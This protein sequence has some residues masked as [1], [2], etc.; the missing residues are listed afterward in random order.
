MIG[1]M[2]V[3]NPLDYG[4]Y[5]YTLKPDAGRFECGTYNIP[6][7]LALKASLELI[8]S[9]GIDAIAQRVK[10]LGDR[11]ID[12][13]RIKG[14]SVI[15]PRQGEQWSGIVSFTSASRDHAALVR[16]L[17]KNHK[18]EIALRE[19]RLRASPHFYNTEEQIDRLI[20]HLPG[21]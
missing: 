10:L 17:R 8:H 12:G 20:E 6:G 19:G 2:N 21:H 4:D 1:W 13:L 3:I 7:L 9:V 16:D 14:Y 18:T 15:S 5:D 11:L